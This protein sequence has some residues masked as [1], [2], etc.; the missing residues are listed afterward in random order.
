MGHSGDVSLA[1]TGARGP[2]SRPQPSR[3]GGQRSTPAEHRVCRSCRESSAALRP[4]TRVSGHAASLG[5]LSGGV[6][7]GWSNVVQPYL[8]EAD[9][10]WTGEEASYNRSHPALSNYEDNLVGALPYVGALFGALFSGD[11]ADSLG[12]R[13]LLL[14]TAVPYMLCWLLVMTTEL[15]AVIL[16]SQVVA[17]VALGVTCTITP[18]YIEEIAEDG[19]RG[20]LEVY[21]DVLLTAGGLLVYV[22]GAFLDY[23][24]LAVAATGVPLVFLLSFYFMPES[25]VYLLCKGERDRAEKALHWLRGYTEQS[26]DEDVQKGI[27][28]LEKMLGQ[29]PAI[30]TTPLLTRIVRVPCFVKDLVLNA[31]ITPA[32]VRATVVVCGLM[33]FQQ[34]CGLSTVVMLAI[35]LLQARSGPIDSQF[36]CFM[37]VTSIEAVSVTASAFVVDRV[38]RRVLLLVSGSLM[39]ACHAALVANSLMQDGAAYPWVLI[40]ISNV[41]IMAFSL[42]VGPIPFVLCAELSPMK[43]KNSIQPLA[44]FLDWGLSF[45]V[46]QYLNTFLQDLG[47][48][49]SFSIFCG[50]CI[51]GTVFVY[52]WVPETK[53]KSREEI[54]VALA[55][56]GSSLLS[57]SQ[58]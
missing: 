33:C 42:G 20:T 7:L 2:L 31:D 1:I 13:R 18:M 28:G 11:V 35:S 22:A 8:Q 52:L 58:C 56:D 10:S 41:Y 51:S 32:A 29:F 48:L 34:L 55:D 46:N 4:A 23:F 6:V 3:D 25:P 47:D 50:I 26:S 36:E 30:D 21:M 27:T 24:W 44:N 43:E 54:Q 17:G 57:S 49:A 39:A 19:I 15:L 45:V 38:G 14:A 16:V 40:L 12:R 53:L 37:I 5:A 9:L